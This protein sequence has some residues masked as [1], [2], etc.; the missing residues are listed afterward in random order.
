[1]TNIRT[2]SFLGLLLPVSLAACG[3]NV[4]SGR[5]VDNQTTILDDGSNVMDAT[6]FGVASKAELDAVVVNS[7]ALADI[8]LGRM[9]DFDDTNLAPGVVGSS[10]RI[11]SNPKPVFCDGEVATADVARMDG[12]NLKLTYEAD[13]TACVSKPQNLA[14]SAGYLA[15]TADQLVVDRQLA[16][17][18]LTF[19]CDSR[20]LAELA[21]NSE[22][23]ASAVMSTGSA[24]SCSARGKDKAA[25][26]RAYR[27]AGRVDGRY[28]G[29]RSEVPVQQRF[30]RGYD[31]GASGNPCMLTREGSSLEGPSNARL[32]ACNLFERSESIN[33]VDNS[34]KG[35]LLTVTTSAR[36]RNGSLFN[37]GDL[38]IKVNGWAA[39]HRFSQQDSDITVDF[40][41]PS[42]ECARY[43]LRPSAVNFE[44]RDCR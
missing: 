38:A 41:R 26:G 34:R 4:I 16:A 5:D 42:G 14:T 2:A 1:M 44:A 30:W 23:K 35:R 11:W 10:A 25:T 32:G 15:P 36:T 27:F 24:F 43:T 3:K 29:P 9:F 8:S 28:I 22:G 17:F 18:S 40:M 33:L 31:A 21:R 6:A 7:M 39:S 37:D 13:V 12:A 19:S 20:D